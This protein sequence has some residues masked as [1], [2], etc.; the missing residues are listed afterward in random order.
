M[1]LLIALSLLLGGCLDLDALRRSR[2]G[3]VSTD[4][5]VRADGGACDASATLF[6]I[7]AD[8]DCGSVVDTWV[9]GSAP[10][11]AQAGQQL[12][13]ALSSN[14]NDAGRAVILLYF[15]LSPVTALGKHVQSASLHVDVESDSPQ[16]VLRRMIATWDASATWAAPRGGQSWLMGCS[17]PTPYQ[18]GEDIAGKGSFTGAG[19]KMIDVTGTVA[20]W[21]DGTASNQGFVVSFDPDANGNDLRLA[22]SVHVVATL[23]P[24][25]IIVTD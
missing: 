17:S 19:P 11:T 12:L 9:S 25:L 21:V 23:R 15:D 22:S 6:T 4:G 13:R 2:D 8:S 5:G 1:R 3:G 18:C 7:G 20:A 24:Q 10:T 16:A 14:S